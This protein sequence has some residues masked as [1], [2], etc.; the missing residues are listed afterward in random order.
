MVLRRGEGGLG[1][2]AKYQYWC[3]GSLDFKDHELCGIVKLGRSRIQSMG[4]T[5]TTRPAQLDRHN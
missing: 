5:S 2:G 3:I 4:E 1:H